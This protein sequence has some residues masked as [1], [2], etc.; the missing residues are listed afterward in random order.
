[1]NQ[2]H[3]MSFKTQQMNLYPMYHKV[4]SDLLPLK[5][6]SEHFPSLACLVSNTGKVS[7]L[8]MNEQSAAK[9]H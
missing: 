7:Q 2:V 4:S 6:E 3:S 1:M 5:T 9:G 8:S